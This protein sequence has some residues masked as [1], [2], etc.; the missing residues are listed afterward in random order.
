VGG[1]FVFGLRFE[2]EF[3]FRNVSPPGGSPTWT[4]NRSTSVWHGPCMQKIRMHNTQGGLKERELK[5][6]VLNPQLTP[7]SPVPPSPTDSLP[8][9][10]FE[11]TI[12]RGR[13]A[14]PAK[15]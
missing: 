8:N 4:E 13:C 9:P 3:P 6:S 1:G 11:S 2:T 10:L 5:S 14:P 7:F 15:G 12:F